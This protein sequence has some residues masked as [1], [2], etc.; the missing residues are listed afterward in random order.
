MTLVFTP[1]LLGNL[2]L[3][4]VST[5]FAATGIDDH[6]LGVR[7]GGDEAF[8]V[9]MLVLISNRK[10]TAERFSVGLGARSGR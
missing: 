9:L 3:I 7:A 1:F 2:L 4:F 6:D 8:F 10:S 5:I